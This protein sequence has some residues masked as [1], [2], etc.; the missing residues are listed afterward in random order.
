MYVGKYFYEVSEI[1]GTCCSGAPLSTLANPP[2]VFAIYIGEEQAERRCG[3]A[4]NLMRVL[5]WAPEMLG[6]PIRDEV[7]NPGI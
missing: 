5:D 6:K 7:V 2:G 1:A 4:M 3:Y